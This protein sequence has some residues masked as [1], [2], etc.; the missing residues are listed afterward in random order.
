M[1]IISHFSENEI[2][3]YMHQALSLAEE[4]KSID[5]VPVGAV[6]V[7]NNQVVGS[8]KNQ[9]ESSGRVVAH[10][11]ILALEDYQSKTHQ[12]RVPPG[13][14]LFVTVEPCIM[15]TGALL[16]SRIDYLYYGCTDSKNAGLRRVQSAIEDG[17]YDH[18]FK[19]IHGS[20]LEVEC[21]GML[22]R[23]FKS[24]RLKKDSV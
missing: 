18:R 12:W 15:C 17:V 7:Y 1:G 24:K 20:I 9:R 4:A 22:S 23:Y 10:A 6:L 11:E 14:A 13:M 21:A 5:E 16:W 2:D 8:G 3:L 19:E